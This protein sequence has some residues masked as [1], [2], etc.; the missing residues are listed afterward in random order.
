LEGELHVLTKLVAFL[1]LAEETEQLLGSLFSSFALSG[2]FIGISSE[3]AAL[4][5][6]NE[7]SGFLSSVLL[8]KVNE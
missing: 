6:F 1:L 4:D 3:K 8:E 2:G 7:T 5:L